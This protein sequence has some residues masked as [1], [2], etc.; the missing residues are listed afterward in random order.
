MRYTYTIL[1]TVKA[2]ATAPLFITPDEVMN[3]E[4]QEIKVRFDDSLIA[5]RGLVIGMAVET[6][7]GP[8]VILSRKIKN[9]KALMEFALLHEVGHIIN[10]DLKESESMSQVKSNWK[11]CWESIC[12][13][14]QKEEL[15][16][17]A[18]A[19]ARIGKTAAINSLKK[20]ANSE[21]FPLSSRKEVMNRIKAIEEMK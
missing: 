18:F 12:G 4:G 10:G 2:A 9:D 13:K 17:D 15:A 5:S 14:V 16:A 11:R 8:F 21:H 1:E 19:V 3:I 20:M 6:S 7:I